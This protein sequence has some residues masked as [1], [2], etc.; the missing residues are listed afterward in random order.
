[1][2]EKLV[3]TFVK[4]D[5]SFAGQKIIDLPDS[6][7]LA[8]E[9]KRRTTQSAAIVDLARRDVPGALDRL[10]AWLLAGETANVLEML[11]ALN[12][13]GQTGAAFRRLANLTGL[14][15]AARESFHSAWTLRGHAM[16]REVSN[17]LLLIKAM[18]NLLPPYT[19]EGMVLYRGEAWVNRCH[20]AY[21]MAWTTRK[22][23][24]EQFA[25]GWHSEGPGGSA[26]L[27]TAASPEAIMAAPNSHSESLGEQEYLVDRRYLSV[28]R[29]L[30]RY[31]QFVRP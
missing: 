16:R 3:I 29:V 6:E 7:L 4:P 2:P 9:E 13:R 23:K 18:R 31:P 11:A 19:G 22:D 15:V 20:R 10:T 12:D 14:T 24:A 17:D 25:Q 1:L 27:E 5:G 8:A 28:V 30:N 26:V 21:G